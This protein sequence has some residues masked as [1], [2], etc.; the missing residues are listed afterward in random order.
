MMA[1]G[2][3]VFDVSG[4]ARKGMTVNDLLYRFQIGAG[5]AFDNDRIL[6]STKEGI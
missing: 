6:L 4:D 5:K 2:S 1:N 3:I